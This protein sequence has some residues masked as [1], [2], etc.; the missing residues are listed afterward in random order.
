MAGDEPVRGYSP[1]PGRQMPLRLAWFAMLFSAGMG[2][3]LVFWGVAEPISHFAAA[4]R[5]APQSSAAAKDAMLLTF[6]HWRSGPWAVYAILGL[7]LGYFGYR[8]GLPLSVRSAL[9]PLIGEAYPRV[10]G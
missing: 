5:E 2:I 10:A 1:G 7:S 9:Y 4:P 8:H 3:G 6:N